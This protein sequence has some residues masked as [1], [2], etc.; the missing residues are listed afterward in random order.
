MKKLEFTKP[1]RVLTTEAAD[2]FLKS[3]GKPVA[4]KFYKTMDKIE[5][6]FI[7]KNILKKLII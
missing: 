4:V 7:D 3:V 6:G 2:E 1:L 5:H